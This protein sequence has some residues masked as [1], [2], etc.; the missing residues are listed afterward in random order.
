MVGRLR[1]A[2]ESREAPAR[3][4]NSRSEDRAREGGGVG[5]VMRQAV[6]QQESAGG[7]DS[8]N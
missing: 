6:Q 2:V 5:P 4:V 7:Y 8:R 1:P 3:R